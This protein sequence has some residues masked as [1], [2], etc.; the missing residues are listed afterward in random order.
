[1]AISPLSD[2]AAASRGIGPFDENVHEALTPGL[3]WRESEKDEWMGLADFN[4]A[5]DAGTADVR[6]LREAKLTVEESTP[7]KSAF[8]ILYALEGAMARDVEERYTIT[9]EGVSVV[10]RLG[11]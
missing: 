10:T 4:I 3:Q 2:S 11:G 1:M 7:A 8:S 9:A 5:E 6:T